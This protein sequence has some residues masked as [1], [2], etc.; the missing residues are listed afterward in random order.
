V[1]LGPF[2]LEPVFLPKVWAAPGIAG[3]L[4][5][6]LKVPERTG[7]VWLASH[8]HHI[9]K[10]AGSPW[11]Q[12]LEG[13][14]LDDVC[15]RWR[16]DL[17]GP[18][19]NGAGNGFPLL[20]KILSVGDW[21]SVQVHPDDEAARRLENESWG[22]SEAWLV[23]GAEEGAEIVM[24]LTPGTDR[25]K[26]REA[27]A[28][29]RLPEMLAKVPA[30]ENDV[31]HLPAGLVHATGPGLT[32]F[33]IQQASD[34]TYRFYDWDRPGADGKLREL[35]VDKALQVMRADGPGS[36]AQT[37]EL[38]GPPNRVSLL[39]D[40]PHFA[41]LNADLEALYQPFLA[42]PALRLLFILSG[43]GSLSWGEREIQIKPGQTWCLPRGLEGLEVQPSTS[44]SLLESIALPA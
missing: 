37:R 21:L 35:H 40:D 26:V 32:I 3:P 34:V 42:Q 5:P 10:V 19:L 39:V 36:P 4:G 6:V 20:I 30:R 25:D 18:E 38:S 31:F 12:D 2:R 9:T 27:V 23:L 17:L 29:G 41:L 15:R 13:L 22:K 14:G 11:N 7:E 44:I 33:E 8:R 43:S 28:Q 16:A 1:S 24:G